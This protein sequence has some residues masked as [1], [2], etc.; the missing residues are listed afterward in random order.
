MS[1]S[2]PKSAPEEPSLERADVEPV[3]AHAERLRIGDETDLSL[4]ELKAV[5]AEI[6][7][8][9]AYI[10]KAVALRQA[11]KQKQAE[12]EKAAL[13]E[14]QRRLVL[15]RK[16]GIG[17]AVAAVVSMICVWIGA[18]SRATEL[19]GLDAEV[20]RARAQLV[21]VTERQA[22]VEAEYR[23]RSASPDRD[24]ELLGAENRVRV[25]R[26]RYDEAAATYNAARGRTFGGWASRLYGVPE[27]APLSDETLRP[28]RAR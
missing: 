24:A 21:S 15:A 4:D 2:Q 5:G 10:E 11:E 6:D 17:A 16:V 25:E 19:R 20:A 23:P 18:S 14:R 8:Q 22:K 7:I 3:I 12:A 27:R 28:E 13:A 1:E 26:M 9:P